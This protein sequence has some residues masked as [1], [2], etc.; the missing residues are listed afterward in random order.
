MLQSDSIS[1]PSLYIHDL[2]NEDLDR[3]TTVGQQGRFVDISE[4]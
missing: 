2:S 4:C 3:L 1:G